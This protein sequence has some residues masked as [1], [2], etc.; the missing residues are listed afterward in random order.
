MMKPLTADE[1]AKLKLAA[2]RYDTDCAKLERRYITTIEQEREQ[3]EKLRGVLR[4]LDTDTR[5]VS[6]DDKEPRTVHLEIFQSELLAAR[7][8]LAATEP[9][10]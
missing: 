9:Q 1:I 2:W 4:P 5:I 10:S 7:L 6:V 3:I 8:V